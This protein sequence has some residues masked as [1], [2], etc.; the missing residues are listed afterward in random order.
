MEAIAYLLLATS[1]ISYIS[2]NFTGSS[3]FTN[4][5][6]ATREVKIGLPIMITAAIAGLVVIVGRFFL[7]LLKG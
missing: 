1:L 2:M 3:T 5:T 4:L 6:G 7:T